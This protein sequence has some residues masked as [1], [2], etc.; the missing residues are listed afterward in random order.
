MAPYSVRR[1]VASLTLLSLLCPVASLLASVPCV[2]NEAYFRPI[3][4]VQLPSHPVDV[5]FAGD[6][7][8]G[9]HLSHSLVICDIAVPSAP[10]L[11][12]AIPSDYSGQG[13]GVSGVHAY[14][15]IPEQGLL[16]FDISDPA[17][18]VLLTTV[19]M[20]GEAQA[21]VLDGNLAFVADGSYGLEVIDVT[22][23]S[24][25]FVIGSLDIESPGTAKNLRVKDEFAYLVDSY[26]GLKVVDISL[27]TQPI[28]VGSLETQNTLNDLEMAGDLIYLAQYS[29]GL[30]IVDVTTPTLPV[31]AGVEFMYSSIRDVMIAGNMLFL[32]HQNYGLRLYDLADPQDPIHIRDLP[33]Q[34]LPHC[35][36][37]PDAPEHLLTFNTE[38]STT[39]LV[40]E[41]QD[42]SFLDS[43]INVGYP[44]P[45]LDV[46]SRDNLAVVALSNDDLHIYDLADPLSPIL[47]GTVTGANLHNSLLALDEQYLYLGASSSLQGTGTFRIYDLTDPASPIEL[48]ALPTG[49]V[50]G[51]AVGDGVAYLSTFVW[52][53]SPYGGWPEGYL[54]SINLTDP[55]APTVIQTTL[56]D[57]FGEL[58]LHEDLL[59]LG[60][61]QNYRVHNVSDP[62]N[63]TQVGLF[64][65]PDVWMRGLTILGNRGYLFRNHIIPGVG[66]SNEM[67][68]WDMT[69][70]IDPVE[71][72]LVML[73]GW[74][75]DIHLLDGAAYLACNQYGVVR[76]DLTDETTPV[77]AGNAFIP[78]NA[79]YL[80]EAGEF[81]WCTANGLQLIPWD[82]DDTYATDVD[83]DQIPSIHP[84]MFAAPNPFN[85][86]TAIRFHLPNDGPVLLTIHDVAGHKV[87]ILANRTFTAGEHTVRWDGRDLYGSN[88]A[89]GIYLLRMNGQGVEETA[90]LTLVR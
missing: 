82:C 43:P 13:I 72:G 29:G 77:M 12:C 65:R 64:H 63:M 22:D 44:E 80:V 90:K 69:D 42:W 81:L 16:V 41:I 6:L 3:A 54:T 23:P 86:M 62:M 83:Q 49:H 68:I 36:G 24:T 67:V 34:G 47:Q 70:P 76:I 73:P 35:L 5:V 33:S 61:N 78:G 45:M 38:Y 74:G 8:I 56:V 53:Q 52:H 85:P 11:L 14:V 88:V 30:A 75:K 40:Y 15:A 17:T 18:P 79:N 71:I 28:I 25:A 48:A 27:P 51:L 46:A 21:V 39:L 4:V 66:S 37:T 32:E 89:S 59:Y 31:L 58:V 50:T 7:S 87:A 19:P 2:D 1:I 55:T 26:A 60:N 84:A 10:V 9:T 20:F 57:A